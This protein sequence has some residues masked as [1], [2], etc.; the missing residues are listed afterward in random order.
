MNNFILGYQAQ[1]FLC[2]ISFMISSTTSA[3]VITE[4]PIYNP[5]LPPIVDIIVQNVTFGSSSRTKKSFPALT[6]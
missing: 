2:L 6:Y 4:T 5:I 3:T 1:H